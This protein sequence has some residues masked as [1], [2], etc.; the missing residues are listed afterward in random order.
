[1]NPSPF[2]YTTSLSKSSDSSTDI[3]ARTEPSTETEQDEESAQECYMCED[4]DSL[5]EDYLDMW[6]DD[7]GELC[8]AGHYGLLDPAHERTLVPWDQVA[9]DLIGPWTV[10]I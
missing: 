10:N 2:K 3:T 9:V 7:F 5:P 8:E 1:M 4:D 6:W